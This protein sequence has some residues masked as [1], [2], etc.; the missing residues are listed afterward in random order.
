MELMLKKSPD[1]IKILS[2]VGKYP[3]G[4]VRNEYLIKKNNIFSYER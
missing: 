4:L 2:V 3:K 1:T